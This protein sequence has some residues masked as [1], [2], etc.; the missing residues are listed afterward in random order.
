MDQL[1]NAWKNDYDQTGRSEDLQWAYDTFKAMSKADQKKIESQITGTTAKYIEAR[2]KGV[3]HKNFVAIAKKIN[4][5][6]VEAGQKEVR[7]IQKR[8][9]IATSVRITDKEKDAIMKAYMT[10][11]NPNAKSKD[12][13][14]L[15][16]DYI[17]ED[18]KLTPKQYV[19]TYR[20]ELDGNMKRADYINKLSQMGYTREV[21]GKLY[22]IYNSTS[23][24]KAM[25]MT[26]AD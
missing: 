20:I 6:P 23:R 9:A 24:G 18:L 22:D 3:S 11:Y 25:Y 16:Y 7:E 19:E 10:D 15:K 12:Y 5:L 4:D 21:A 13:S 8:E 17:R 1:S 26:K 2:D 14:E